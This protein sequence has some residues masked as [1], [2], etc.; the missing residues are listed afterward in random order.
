[1]TDQPSLKHDWVDSRA[2]SMRILMGDTCDRYDRER[3]RTATMK[4][5]YIDWSDVEGSRRLRNGVVIT[6]IEA[7]ADQPAI[8]PP[9]DDV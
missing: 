5:T 4:V 9:C 8:A 2:M 6:A 7:P 3:E 1:M